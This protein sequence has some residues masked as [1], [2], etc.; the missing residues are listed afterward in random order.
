MRKE[1]SILVKHQI[2]TFEKE[3]FRIDGGY[4]RIEATVR[5]DDQCGNGC[6]SFS[7]T[8]TITRDSREYSGGCIHE[9]IIEH[10]PE[11]EKYI[12]WHLMDSDEPM[13][14]VANTLYHASTKDVYGKEKGE[15]YNFKAGLMVNNSPFIQFYSKEVI[16]VIREL[17]TSYHWNNC[18]IIEVPHK[19]GPDYLGSKFTLDIF[20]EF[21][22]EWHKCT[23]DQKQDA[24]E[25]LNAMSDCTVEIVHKA[26][27]YGK[28]REPDIEAGRRSAIWPNATLDQLNN[29]DELELHRLELVEEFKADL[30]EL[31]LVY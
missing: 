8:G 17:G 25:F 18:Q 7:I 1:D 21:E 11:L 20:S 22:Q 6:N 15:P 16:A 3:G 14:Y 12:K 19:R 31:D 26:Q 13:H 24:F 9:D 29:K 27:S 23:F 28:G 5:Y 4:G 2:K 10:F 30:L